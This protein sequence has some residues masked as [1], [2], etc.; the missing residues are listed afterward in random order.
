MKKVTS[1]NGHFAQIATLTPGCVF[2]LEEM[3]QRTELQL[4]LISN[5]AECIFISKKMFLKRA[6]P[7]S[8]RMIG[9]LVGRYPTEAYIREQLRELN[10]W[11]SFKKD[12]VKHVL[13]KKDK[14]SSSVVM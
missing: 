12:V 1:S 7:R 14:T 10:Q 4:T 9:A 13:E 11:K 5:G 6:T 8:L 3:M 2:G